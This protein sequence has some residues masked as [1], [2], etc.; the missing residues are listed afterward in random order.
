MSEPTTAELC[1]I[2]HG[3]SV[4]EFAKWVGVSRATMELWIK[5]G[6]GPHVLTVQQ[7]ARP[8]RR[9]TPP[10]AKAWLRRRYD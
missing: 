7:S 4:P 6:T 5:E 3:M 9:I 10:A 2:P 1:T 8:T